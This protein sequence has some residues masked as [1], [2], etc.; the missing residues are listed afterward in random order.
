[1]KLGDKIFSGAIWSL[2]ER[3]STQIVQFVLG[4]FL[5]RLLS[6]K[7]FGLIGLLIV[8]ITISQVFVDS[9]FTKA[10]IQKKDRNK[11][12]IST[13]FIFNLIISIVCYIILWF[14]AP[15][16]ADFY[17]TPI[18]ISLLRVLSISLVINAIFTVPATLVT[19]DLN[20]K[21]FA[22]ANLIAVIISGLTAIYLAYNDFGVW[23]LVYQTLIKATIIGIL[24]LFWTK[25]KP[26]LFFSK[27]S[28]KKLFSY[29]SK[30]LLGSL[31]NTTVSN[32][33]S[34]FIAK[35]ISTKEL[36]Y[37]AQGTQFTD[38]IFKTVNA[39]VDKVLLPSLSQIQDQKEVLIKYSKNIIKM[40][41]IFI[42][43]IFFILIII[44]EPLIKVLLTEK[45]L[46]VVPIMQLFALARLITII[47]GI[48][49]NLLYVLGR[50][51]LALKQQFYKIPIRLALLAASIKFGI[52]YVALAE[53]IATT[54]HYFYDSYYPGKIMQYGAK[55]Q[56]KD[57]SKIFFI[58]ILIGIISF[59]IMSYIPSSILKML[60]TP[61]IYVTLYFT[62]NLYLKIPEFLDPFN[63]LKKII[64]KK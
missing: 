26:L 8:F 39:V 38:L 28:F 59:I 60:V 61:I 45:W 47:C 51:D 54:I 1:M 32:V 46:P 20:F 64:L 34:L 41:S 55:S 5:A 56:I 7:D 27:T 37:Y 44:A 4:I 31:M 9:G 25:W 53:L 35:I 11:N 29:G 43:P 19:I 12:D 17:E 62:A 58:N 22:K 50:T 49:V 33:A 18:L 21:L 52:I 36:G 24:L 3:L 57:L 63:K 42:T 15:F 40:V 48:N 23:S 30:L 14:I 6:P 10:L 2:V 13:V 16:I